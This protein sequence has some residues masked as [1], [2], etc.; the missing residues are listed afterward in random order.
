MGES[1]LLR[2]SFWIV[3]SSYVF[4]FVRGRACNSFNLSTRIIESLGALAYLHQR[5]ILHGDIKA[6]NPLSFPVTFIYKS[7]TSVYPDSLM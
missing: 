3:Y 1:L 2:L 7:A 6:A 5:G 4:K